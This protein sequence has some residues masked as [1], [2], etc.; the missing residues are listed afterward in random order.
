[1]K[2]I[3][4]EQ[5]ELKG[6]TI[7]YGKVKTTFGKALMAST[8]KGICYFAF[9]TGKENLLD[10]LKKR[11]KGASFQDKTAEFQQN[12]L[13]FDCKNKDA[14]E[15]TLHLKGT[16]FQLAVWQELLKIPVGKLQTYSGIAQ[17]IGRP[18]AARAVGTAVG[19]NPVSFIIPCHRVVPAT[20]GFGGYRWGVKKKKEILSREIEK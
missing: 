4:L 18:K 16:D 14:M 19:S 2:T 13:S 6:L 8:D 11:F 9:E 10:D 5:S 15:M 3:R 20:G 1:M 17:K 12:A 7:Y